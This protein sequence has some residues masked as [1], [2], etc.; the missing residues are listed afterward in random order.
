MFKDKVIDHLVPVSASET[1]I[2][3]KDGSI[4]RINF[5]IGSCRY[6]SFDT[7]SLRWAEVHPTN[8]N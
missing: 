2:H 3:F 4:L 1:E 8:L 5:L 7:K 6:F